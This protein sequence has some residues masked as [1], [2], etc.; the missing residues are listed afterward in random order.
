MADMNDYIG[1]RVK[2]TLDNNFYYKGLVLSAGEDYISLRDIHDKL[3]YINLK[4]VIS[5]VEVEE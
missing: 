3:T 4:N 1:K 5:I 2:I